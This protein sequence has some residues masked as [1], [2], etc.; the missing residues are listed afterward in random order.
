MAYLNPAERSGDRSPVSVVVPFR[1]DRAAATRLVGAL[2]CLDRSDGDEVVVADNTPGGL[3]GTVQVGEV[4]VVNA[5]R[6][7]SSYHARNAGARAATGDWILFMDAD[8]IPQP[9]LLAAYF[10]EP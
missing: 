5:P 1:G 10:A 8:C 3:L 4:Q 9:D 2:G 6:Q 7:R